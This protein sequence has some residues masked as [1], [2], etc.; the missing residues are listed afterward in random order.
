MKIA[1]VCIYSHPS[2][3]GVWSRVYNLGKMLKKKGHE[4]SVFSTNVVKGV[5]KSSENFENLEGIKI[6]R[7]KPLFSIGENIKF[8]SFY[9]KLKKFNPDLIIAEV[10]RHPH[11]YFALKAA[12][13]L[14]KPIFLTTHAP[15]VEA[16]LRSKKGDFIEKSYDKIFGKK[17]NQ[18]DKIITITKWEIPYLL[19]LGANK[20]KFE[21]IPNGI[22]EEFFE[23][24]RLEASPKVQNSG[25]S[26]KDILFLGRISAIKDLTT[27]IKALS[28]VVKKYPEVSLKFVGPAEKEYEFKLKKLINKLNLEKNVKFLP[29]VYDLDKKIKIID[30]AEIFVL[31]SKRE[32]MPQSLIEAMARGK[33][34]IASNNKGSS[35]II[36]NNKNGFLFPI[37]DE[38]KLAETIEFCLNSKNKKQLNKIKKNAFE[39][40]KSFA[41]IKIFKD[42]YKLLK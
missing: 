13:K 12:K 2:I 32:A 16:E 15:F 7:F 38:N 10:Y 6:N 41:W 3:C 27:L 19:N 17:I 24:R 42:F 36:E 31:P 20:N 23:K 25:R 11:T 4:V 18:F 5:G 40:S 9:K 1:F 33:I 37:S 26:G 28:K 14:G 34:V 29:A 39:K 22:P 21:Y 30:E 35:E 8:W